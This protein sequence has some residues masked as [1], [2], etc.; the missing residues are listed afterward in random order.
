MLLDELECL[1]SIDS[2]GVPGIVA[3][4]RVFISALSP[5]Y[6]FGQQNVAERSCGRAVP[7]M[8][9]RSRAA[10]MGDQWGPLLPPVT[11]GTLCLLRDLHD[12]GVMRP[13]RRAGSREPN[14]RGGASQGD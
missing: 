7:P 11:C 10:A 5:P 1:D 13:R 3:L 12:R 4:N 8:R 2:P 9:R 6:L 14:G